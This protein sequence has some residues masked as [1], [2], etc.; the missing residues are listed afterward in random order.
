MPKLHHTLPSDPRDKSEE[1]LHAGEQYSEETDLP[2]SEDDLDL[3]QDGDADDYFDR[4]GEN[5]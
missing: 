5:G 4:N 2:S 3:R 1:E